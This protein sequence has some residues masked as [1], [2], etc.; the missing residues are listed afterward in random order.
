MPSSALRH[1]V[2]DQA[3]VFGPTFASPSTL[4]AEKEESVN[5]AEF[6]FR[7]VFRVLVISKGKK[8]KQ[9]P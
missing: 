4:P 1:M 2:L 7:G 6:F 9:F 5:S 3:F 8:N